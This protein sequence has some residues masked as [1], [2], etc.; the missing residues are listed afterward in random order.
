V[1]SL[2]IS[3]R[4]AAFSS[5]NAV[6]LASASLA[7]VELPLWTTSALCRFSSLHEAATKV[8]AFFRSLMPSPLRFDDIAATR[9]I[10]DTCLVNSALTTAAEHIRISSANSTEICRVNDIKRLP[11]LPETANPGDDRGANETIE[12]SSS[13][14]ARIRSALTIV[15]S[16][17]AAG[18]RKT[19]SAT[20]AVLRDPL[21]TL[22]GG[23]S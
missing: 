11:F 18:A 2:V 22:R 8:A 1:V 12:S 4:K 13:D 6:S 16:V 7:A 3:L 5:S 9:K 15:R 17:I 14:I 10:L 19:P 21:V 20:P 23:S